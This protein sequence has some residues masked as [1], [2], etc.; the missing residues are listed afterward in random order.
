MIV[1]PEVG[2]PSSPVPLIAGTDRPDAVAQAS[3]QAQ[4]LPALLGVTEL[5]EQAGVLQVI[6]RL[7][8]LL[9][10]GQASLGASRAT[11]CPSGLAFSGRAA[12]L[13]RTA[14][15]TRS[16]AMLICSSFG[17]CSLR[18]CASRRLEQG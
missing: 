5:A 12:V 1:I 4:K 6:G 13:G 14:T 9:L 3:R 17:P 15:L 8:Q 10:L 16:T 7:Q 18:A 11:A 2:R